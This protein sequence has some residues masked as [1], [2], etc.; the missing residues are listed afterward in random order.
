MVKLMKLL[1]ENWRRQCGE[2][3]FDILCENFDRGLIT[4]IELY[5][6]WDRQV[7]VE[8]QTL[9]DEGVMD[10]LRKG[11]EA[12]K[13]GAKEEWELI[14]FAYHKALEKVVNVYSRI[15]HEA[16]MLYKHP[17][18]STISGPPLEKIANTLTK[19]VNFIKKF[20]NVHPILC[21][22][23]FALVVLLCI[24]AVM[25]LLAA[26]LLKNSGD[27][28]V[29]KSAMAHSTGQ[30]T[31]ISSEGEYV[32]TDTGV[33]ATK[34]CLE[35][36]GRHADP[37]GQQLTVD[38]LEWLDK[39]HTAT[40]STNIHSVAGQGAEL[41]QVCYE[42]MVQDGT[43][44]Q[45]RHL[46]RLGKNVYIDANEFSVRLNDVKIESIKWQSLNPPGENISRLHPS[47][48]AIKK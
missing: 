31:S 38:A 13:T 8:M 33:L 16:Y 4:E 24:A 5:E 6:T 18:M 48:L 34:G 14:K 46:V 10:T 28:G 32:I 45:I 27:V 3:D 23:I 2:Y 22:V 21:K 11:Y 26:Y 39:A 15:M 44:E 43:P 35:Y 30:I 25:A 12:L 42:T 20:C 9:L 1:L 47:K 37:E 17:M 7:M 40:T 41:A 36:I 29:F 19:A